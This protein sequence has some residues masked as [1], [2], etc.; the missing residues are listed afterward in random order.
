MGGSWPLLGVSPGDLAVWRLLGFSVQ[1][2]PSP[3]QGSRWGG[4]S[5]HTAVKLPRQDGGHLINKELTG[6]VGRE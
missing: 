6:W 5:Q 1:G 4:I 2:L 3:L